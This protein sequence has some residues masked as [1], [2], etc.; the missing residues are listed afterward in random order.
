MLY[1]KSNSRFF[2]PKSILRG[3]IKNDWLVNVV[4]LGR[5]AAFTPEQEQGLLDYAI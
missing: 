3:K 1:P 2:I 5:K 4:C